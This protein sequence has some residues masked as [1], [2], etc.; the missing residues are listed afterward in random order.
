MDIL[1]TATLHLNPS[2]A[3]VLT[4]DRPR[5]TIEKKI[6]WS[7][8][9]MYDE[10]NFIIMMGGLHIEMTFVLVLGQWLE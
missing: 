2:Q 6:Q 5:Y 9:N 8:P 3:T 4:V 7:F 10:Q 1:Q